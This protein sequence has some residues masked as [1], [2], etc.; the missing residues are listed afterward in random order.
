M[1][2]VMST[3]QAVGQAATIPLT[4]VSVLKGSTATKN[5]NTIMLNKCGVYKIDVDGSVTIPAGNSVSIELEKN[6]VVQAQAVSIITA[7]ADQ[8]AP[9]AFSTLVQVPF[10]NTPAPASAPTQ[11][12]FVSN[13]ATTYVHFNVVVT[14]IA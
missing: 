7:V 3:N 12:E 4:D 14:K 13:E 2:Q 1:L 6:G 5:G 10:S 9:F 11:V 8:V